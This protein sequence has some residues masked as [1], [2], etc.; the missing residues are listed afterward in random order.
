MTRDLYSEFNAFDDNY[1]QVSDLHTIHYEQ[2]GNPNGRPVIILHG[3]PGGG[4]NPQYRRYFNPTKWRIVQ[5]SQ[6]GC[7]KSTPF[8]ELRENTTWDLV[9]DIEKLRNHLKIESWAVFGGSWGSTLSLTYSQTHPDRCDALFLRG[10]FLLRKKEIDWF[11]Q[12]GCSKIYPDAWQHF[13]APIPESEQGDLLTAYHKRL[14]SDDE[15]IRRQAARAWSIWEGSTSKLIQDKNVIQHYGS[16]RFAE[17]FARIECHYFI[18]KGFFKNE[19]QLI[20]NVDVIRGIPAVIVQGRYDVV[21]PVESAWELSRA[22]PE[23]NLH[24]V[25]D[26][27]HSMFEKGIRRKL[28]QATDDF[29]S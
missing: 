15:S 17:A 10:I 19:E 22:W 1:L 12:Q 13:L 27:G 3:G 6:R 29:V 18:N 14:T 4:M 16:D 21:C 28:V 9:A 23:A 7:G 26:S 2:S 8:A 25:A 5:F 24:I 20:D 11:Y